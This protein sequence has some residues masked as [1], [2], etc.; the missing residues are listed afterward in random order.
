M[1]AGQYPAIDLQHEPVADGQRT[2]R[3]L[4]RQPV[5]FRVRLGSEQIPFTRHA[6]KAQRAV[7]L[8]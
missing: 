3:L 8:I 5:Y 7:G 4:C 6:A 1:L 2:V